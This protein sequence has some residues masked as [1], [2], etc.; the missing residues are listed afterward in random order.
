M[1]ALVGRKSGLFAEHRAKPRDICILIY[2]PLFGCMYTRQY[3]MRDYV[4]LRVELLI[5]QV[6]VLL[7][8]GRLVCNL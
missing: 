1:F 6:D 5:V 8:A 7:I 3:V 4:K 2:R